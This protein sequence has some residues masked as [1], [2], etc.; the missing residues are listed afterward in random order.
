MQLR[1]TTFVLALAWP[2]VLMAAESGFLSD[3][4][5]LE[6]VTT[7]TGT[8]RGYIAPDAM[9]RGGA[10]TAVLIDQPEIHFSADSEY[11]GMKPENI[12]ALAEIIR[13]A[14]RETIES[15]GRYKVVEE[16]AANALFLRT[17]LTDLYVKKKKRPALAYTPVGAMVKVGVDALKDVLDK[18]DIIEMALEAEV[19]DS[20]SGEILAAIVI[21]RGARKAAGQKEQRLDMNAFRAI[22]AEYADRL[23]CRLDNS[24]LPEAQWID[25]TDP[26]ARK[27]RG[28]DPA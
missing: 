24:R 1:L 9:A 6:A 16:P 14:I 28:D 12:E 11:R 13:G 3:Y 27:A 8:D 25:C 18:V 5:K 19:A 23:H 22:V 21:E 2:T 4:S 17:A 20:Q 26:A 7:P 10:Y 15:R